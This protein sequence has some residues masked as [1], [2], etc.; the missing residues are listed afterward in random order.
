MN[1]GVMLGDLSLLVGRPRSPAM[2]QPKQFEVTLGKEERAQLVA[3]TTKGISV[4]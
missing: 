3:F 2:S 1:R 4:E